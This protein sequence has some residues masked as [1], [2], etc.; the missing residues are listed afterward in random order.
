MRNK[1]TKI[2]GGILADGE[3]T[4][5]AHRVTVDVFEGLN[6]IREFEGPTTVTHEEHKP[7]ELTNQKLASAQVREFDY[8]TQMARP[9]RD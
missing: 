1:R 3:L 2:K 5:H 9:V 8:L 6:G 7:I 4:R